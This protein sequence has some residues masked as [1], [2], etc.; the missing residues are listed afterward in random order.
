MECSEISKTW[1][2]YHVSYDPLLDEV[3]YHPSKFNLSSNEDKM[4]AKCGDY[5]K[6]GKKIFGY[7]FTMKT[8]R[9]VAL[10]HML[11]IIFSKSGAL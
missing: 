6:L 10:W 9:D 1:S 4:F 5:L 3:L 7:N 8:L 11:K 2:H